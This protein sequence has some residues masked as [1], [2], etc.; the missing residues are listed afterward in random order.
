M[1]RGPAQ[2]PPQR[3][4]RRP[5]CCQNQY[6]AGSRH[7]RT[8][9]TVPIWSYE[10]FGGV[11]RQRR[12]RR[13][14][15]QRRE[16]RQ[17]QRRLLLRRQPVRRHVDAADR[18][19]RRPD[20]A[21]PPARDDWFAGPH[22]I[23]YPHRRTASAP[24]RRS[25][26][27]GR[28]HPSTTSCIDEISSFGLPRRQLPA[29]RP[30]A[31]VDADRAGRQARRSPSTP[32]S[33]T[34]PTGD[35]PLSYTLGLRRRQPHGSGAT[36]N[37]VY[38]GGARQKWTAPR[39]GDRQPAARATRANVAVSTA[40]R[41]RRRS[42]ITPNKPG[43]YAV[44]EAVG[45]TA[46]ATGYNTA[47]QPYAIGGTDIKWQLIIHHCPPDRRRLPPPPEHAEPAAVRARRF[48]TIVPD[49][50]DDSLPRVQGHGHRRRQPEHHGQLQPA[51]VDVHTLL[52]GSN[53]PGHA[54]HGEREPACRRRWRRRPSPTRATSSSPRPRRHGLPVRRVV[55][56]RSTDTTKRFTMPDAD[57]SI[58]ACYGGPCSAGGAAGLYTPV[59]PYR[60][61]DT[62]DPATSPHGRRRPAAC[63]ARHGRRP[64]EP[65]GRAR[66]AR[67]PCCSTSPPTSR[68]RPAT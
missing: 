28:Q 50:G 55:R 15:R 34:T 3:V 36:V 11:G 20:R 57:V 8:A 66:P 37:H 53:V 51:D 49:H 68:R 38:P 64:V 41:R 42:R 29:G 9:V 45:L 27:A 62:R 54:D 6:N 17:L 43:A 40:A 33:P 1:L 30:G 18:R 65:A 59:Q 14:V 31:T 32:A 67:R 61:F 22:N 2:L 44:G 46:A 4:R 52:V 10:H 7:H 5:R 16:L 26:C 58:S 39:H 35:N 24:D 25:T 47:D 60:L 56:R 23:G 21:C 13:R 12:H 48:N 19:Q 63:P